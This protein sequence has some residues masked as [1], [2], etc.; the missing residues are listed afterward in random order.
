MSAGDEI[1]QLVDEHDQVVGE[2][3]R[4]RCTYVFVFNRSGQLLVHKRTP[5]KDVYPGFYDAAAG[6]VLTVS[7]ARETRGVQRIQP[8]IPTGC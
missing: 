2:A 3:A 5:S 6:G 7:D 4:H 8:K 1:V